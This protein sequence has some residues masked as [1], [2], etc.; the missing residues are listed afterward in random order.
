MSPLHE[1]SPVL[2]GIMGTTHLD[3][4]LKLISDSQRRRI[5]HQLRDETTGKATVED[6]VEQ[7][8]NGESAPLTAERMDRDQLSI[9]LIHNHLP[10]LD[11]HEII[12]YDQENKVVHYRPD[13]QI[14]TVL[15]ALPAE[16]VQTPPDS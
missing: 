1:A 4:Y 5:I 15:D 11:E 13:K 9:Q 2:F 10:K 14:E 8:Y 16:V 3:T 6:L 7:L 12:Q